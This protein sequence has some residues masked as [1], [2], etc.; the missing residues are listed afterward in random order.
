MAGLRPPAPLNPGSDLSTTGPIDPA[1]ADSGPRASP[2]VAFFIDRPIFAGV[3]AILITLAGRGLG[4]AAAHLPVSAD[5]PAEGPGLGELLRRQR[6]RRRADRH[7][8]DRRAGQR[9]RGHA[10]HVLGQRQRRPDEPDRD[11][12]ARHRRRHRHGQRDQPRRRRRAPSARG[13]PALRHHRAQAGARPHDGREPVLPRR[14]AG[15]ALPLELRADQHRRRAE[16]RPRRRRDLAL[17]PRQPAHVRALPRHRRR[18]GRAPRRPR[19]RAL[20]LGRARRSEGPGPERRVPPAR[21]GREDPDGRDARSSS[22][23]S[24]RPA[25]IRS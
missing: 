10:L 12:R 1:P 14:L 16:A 3:I 7:A 5:R 17:R 4:A 8:P 15:H 20:R 21:P 25:W 9:D 13:G 22:S 2:F 18:R 24:S 19:D 11:L 6:R 23:T